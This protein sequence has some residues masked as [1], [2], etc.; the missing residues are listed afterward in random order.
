MDINN[1]IYEMFIQLGVAGAAL[2]LILVFIIL[3]FKLFSKISWRENNEQNSR[4]DKL[5][6]KIDNLISSYAENT[7]KLNEVLLVNDK[8]QKNTLKTLNRLLDIIIDLQKKIEKIDIITSK[9]IE[10]GD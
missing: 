7:Q 3:L 9:Y 6:D 1:S 4:I 10:K 2:L 8:D 5:C